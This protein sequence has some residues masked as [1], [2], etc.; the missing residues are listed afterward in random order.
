L[1]PQFGF[2]ILLLPN[3]RQLDNWTV[4]G[5]EQQSNTTHWFLFGRIK[6]DKKV[7]KKKKK[8]IK[9]TKKKKI[10]KRRV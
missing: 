8:N 3:K 6:K 7:S 2:R 5:L 1:T 10:E 4:G 9:R